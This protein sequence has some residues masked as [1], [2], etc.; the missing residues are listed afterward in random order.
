MRSRRLNTLKA[1]LMAAALPPL[2]VCAAE[3]E[4]AF[5]EKFG[6]EAR[7]V[8]ASSERDDDVTFAATLL[9]AADRMQ[10]DPALRVFV[11]E[12]AY[13][14]GIKGPKGRTTAV[15]AAQQLMEL[16]PRKRDHWEE[17]ALM[18]D[19][20]LWANTGSKDVRR[21]TLGELVDRFVALADARVEA[22]KYARA[23]RL[24][25]E[26]VVGAAR[27]G[28][29]RKEEIL[30]KLEAIDALAEIDGRAERLKQR[31][32]S[33]PTNKVAAAQL[34]RLYLVERDDPVEAAKYVELGA[35]DEKQ[36][37]LVLVAGMSL[38]KLPEKAVLALGD[39]YR[40]LATGAGDAR[41]AMLRRAKMYYERYLVLH[42]DEDESRLL[43]E[44]RLGQVTKDLEP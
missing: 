19:F 30:K 10:A 41:H 39:G 44:V 3:P 32:A 43:V 5:N 28:P 25:A 35:E 36:K 11:Y 27:L 26:A 13:G 20:L 1:L 40:Q 15:R 18:A 8:A 7:K 24:Y 4:E 29:R 17:K 21:K 37:R 23:A 6:Y 22:G 31:L 14:F 38:E 34:V 16:V 33:E 12:K 42:A 9:R 2:A